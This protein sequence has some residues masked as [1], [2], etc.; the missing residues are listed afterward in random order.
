M[1]NRYGEAALMAVQ[2]ETHGKAITAVERW[3]DAIGKLYPAAQA[4]QRKSGPK[5]AFV[6]LC[7]AGMV[8]DVR[9]ESGAL[10]TQLR[11][12]EQLAVEAVEL[13]RSGTRAGITELWA[14]VGGGG[15]HDNQMDVV[16]ALWK[17]GLIVGQTAIVGA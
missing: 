9:A 14:G 13:L 10:S 6:G 4:A 17:N 16:L 2:M 15:A 1:A 7:V 8:K 3:Q 12:H 11:R 5:G